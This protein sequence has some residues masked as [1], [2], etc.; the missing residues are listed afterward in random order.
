[1]RLSPSNFIATNPEVLKSIISTQGQSIQNGIVNLLGD[2]KK[3]KVSQ[4][5]ESLLLRLEK[6]L[7]QLKVRWYSAMISLN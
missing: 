6:I 1:M 3:G 5:D 7:P 2:M 4:T